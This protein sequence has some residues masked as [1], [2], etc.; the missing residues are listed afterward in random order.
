MRTLSLLGLFAFFTAGCSGSAQLLLKA[1]LSSK[2]GETGL[3]ACPELTEGALAFVEGDKDAAKKKLT[4]AVA[5]NAPEKVKTFARSLRVLASAPGLES[6]A[7]PLAELTVLLE[8]GGDGA[9]DDGGALSGDERSSPT[10][11]AA[12]VRSRDGA[13]AASSATDERPLTERLRT[14]SVNPA[15]LASATR[16]RLAPYPAASEGMVCA[17]AMIGPLVLSDVRAGASC[18]ADLFVFA[19][20]QEA[21]LWVLFAGKREGFALHGAKLLVPEDVPLTVGL[22]TEDVAGAAANP[23]CTVTWAGARP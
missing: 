10:A 13:T 11:K 2:C 8:G 20:A 4:A 5:Q 21:P 17:R 16:C 3:R 23:A 1:P 7:A 14:A 15:A 6:L 22:R 18:A 9:P 12:T 19:G